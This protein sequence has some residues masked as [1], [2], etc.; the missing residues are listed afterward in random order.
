[1]QHV[2]EVKTM[3]ETIARTPANAGPS[4]VRTHWADHGVDSRSKAETT[5]SHQ[6]WW[7]WSP[8]Q[9]KEVREICSHLTKAERNHVSLLGLLS[10]V[11]VVGTV[12][13]IPAFVR[14]QSGSGKWVV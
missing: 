6:D 13:G 10:A 14:S 11:W 12:S 8:L 9:P 1:Y 5:K 7:T 3:V 4:T 2:S